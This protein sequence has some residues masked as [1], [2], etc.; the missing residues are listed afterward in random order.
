MFSMD[1]NPTILL[2]IFC[3]TKNVIDGRLCRLH[4]TS[5]SP[6]NGPRERPDYHEA[7]QTKPLPDEPLYGWPGRVSG[8][9]RCAWGAPTLGNKTKVKQAG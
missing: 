7:A 2:L 9:S 8:T 4:P 5:G 1:A 6:T 3:Q